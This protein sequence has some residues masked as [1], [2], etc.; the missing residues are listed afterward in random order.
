MGYQVSSGIIINSL[1]MYS[2][3]GFAS[4]NSSAGMED[5]LDTQFSTVNQ[6]TAGDI[7]VVVAYGKEVPLTVRGTA[8]TP[9]LSYPV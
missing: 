9:E 8:T 4:E 3:H 5:I 6:L 7:F 2:G 1:H